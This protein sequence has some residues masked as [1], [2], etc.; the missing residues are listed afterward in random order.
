MGPPWGAMWGPYPQPVA[1]R[2]RDTPHAHQAM[3]LGPARVHAPPP[4]VA[5]SLAMHPARPPRPPFSAR[6]KPSAAGAPRRPAALHAAARICRALPSEE[7]PPGVPFTRATAPAFSLFNTMA[8]RKEPFLPREDMGNRVTMYVCGITAYDFSHV[9]HA[10]AYVC[11]DVLYRHLMRLGYD[12]TYARNFTDVDDK[13]I[14]RADEIRERS[15]EDPLG[16]PTALAAEFSRA[17]L[18][19]MDALSCLRPHHEPRATE[20]IPEMVEYIESIISNKHAYPVEG[21]AAEDGED[22]GGDVYFEVDTLPGY[23]ALSGRDPKKD[24]RAGER[25]AVDGRKR[26]PFD[27]ALWKGARK[28]DSIKWD[29]P[30]GLGRPGWHIE[31]TAMIRKTFGGFPIDIHGGGRDLQ[32]PHHENEL[33]QAR[34]GQCQCHGDDPAAAAEGGAYARYWM[35]NGFVNVDNTKMSKSLGNFF[36]IRDVFEQYP[37]DAL[38]W[39]IVA[40]QYRSDV[41]Y[42]D[43]ALEMACDTLFYNRATLL[44]G[45]SALAALVEAGDEKAAA[46]KAPKELVAAAASCTE[47][48]DAAMADDLNTPMVIASTVPVLKAINDACHTKAGRKMKGRQAALEALLAAAYDAFDR[49]GF[50]WGGE[51]AAERHLARLDEYRASALRRAGLTP[52]ELAARIAAREEARRNKDY[53]ASDAVRDELAVLGISLQDGKV[54]PDGSPAWRPV[55]RVRPSAPAPAPAVE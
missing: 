6:E 30:W 37:P 25:V 28:S 53:A 52:A 7:A 5:H 3:A 36:T 48:C 29:S 2:R 26:G 32:F 39:L 55:P 54:A 14:K 35:H 31:C 50:E 4:W 42:S 47:A 11:Y 40:T 33:A 23:G 17:F 44:D 24:N 8:K 15:A 34:A 21:L 19:D 20:H 16:D 43:A 22:V 49:L 51:G 1:V 9:G 27:F 10:R 45:E 13:I 41:N 12:V 18:E 38:R 46:A